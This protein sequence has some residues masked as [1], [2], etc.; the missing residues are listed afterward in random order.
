MV[1]IKVVLKASSEKRKRTQ[2]FPTPESPIRSSLK[3]RSYVFFAIGRSGSGS[4]RRRPQGIGPSH[5]GQLLTRAFSGRR[6]GK[7][8]KKE[9]SRGCGPPTNSFEEAQTVPPSSASEGGDRSSAASPSRSARFRGVGRD[10]MASPPPSGFL[11]RDAPTGEQACSAVKEGRRA[12]VQSLPRTETA[13]A[14]R[15]H[16]EG[17]PGRRAQLHNPRKPSHPG[18]SHLSPVP[19]HASVRA[20]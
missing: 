13:L 3:S 19:S 9:S 12:C 11:G 6:T 10:K 18:Q 2:V 8:G 20:A 4:R 15:E 14:R 17:P 1:E 16:S 5:Y 7:R